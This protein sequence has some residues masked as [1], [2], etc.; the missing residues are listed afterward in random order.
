MALH[1]DHDQLSREVPVLSGDAP[2]AVRRAQAG[3]S[4]AFAEVIAAYERIVYTV[5]LRM[6][7]DRDE[8]EDVTQAV[9]VKTYRSIGDYDPRRRFFSWIYRI[10]LNE[11]IDQLRR[12]RPAAP[13]D[14][15]MVD[16]GET[17]EDRAERQ[18][19]ESIVQEVMLKLTEEHREVIVLRHYLHRSYAEMSEALRL[20]ESTVK[21]RLFEARQRL[22]SLLQQRGIHS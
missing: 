11:C 17:P 14:P 22:G 1:R 12:K 16:P 8:A 18:E 7:G 3:D 15:Q 21:S 20:P 9:F 5:A 10:T 19:R 13:L 6:T 2:E 4:R